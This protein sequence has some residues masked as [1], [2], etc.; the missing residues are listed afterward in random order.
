MSIRFV[1]Y[2]AIDPVRWNECIQQDTNVL[3]Y[4]RAEF[5]TVMCAHWDALILDDYEAVMP[6]VSRKKWGIR[7]LY[8]PPF[9]QQIG[10]FGN[11]DTGVRQ[12]FIEEAQKLFRFA[13]IHLHHQLPTDQCIKSRHNQIIDLQKPYSDLRKNYSDYT[14]R[15]LKQADAENTTYQV[16]PAPTNIRAYQQLFGPRTPHVPPSAY[17][18][19]Q[20]FCIQ[21]PA[22]SLSRGIFLD[23]TLIASVTALR[24]E[25]RLHLLTLTAHNRQRY[26][27]ANHLLIDQLIRECANQPMILD[28]EGSDIPGVFA[29][30]AGFGAVDQPYYFYKWNNLPWVVRLLKK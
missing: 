11:A 6:L 20:Q 15:K 4:A 12:A 16:I 27:W 28:F 17:E 22:L 30:N 3:V 26:T 13:E 19:L 14:L 18:R 25:Q 7:Y 8:Q 10:V 2:K 9:I 24:T 23:N 21:Y 5:L 29:F 1:P